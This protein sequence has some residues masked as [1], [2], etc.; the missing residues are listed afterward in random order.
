MLLKVKVK[1]KKYCKE[2]EEKNPFL[3]GGGVG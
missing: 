2:N 1:S 3:G